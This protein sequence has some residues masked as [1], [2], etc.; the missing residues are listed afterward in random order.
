MS[1][2]GDAT[3][4]INKSYR[5]RRRNIFMADRNQ[6]QSTGQQVGQQGGQQSGQQG[7]PQ[8][9]SGQPSAQRSGAMEAEE[10]GRRGARMARRGAYAPSMFALSPGSVFSMSPFELIR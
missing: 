9:Q 5:N 10:R 2:A 4:V 1:G 8:M 3:R 6:N 7:G